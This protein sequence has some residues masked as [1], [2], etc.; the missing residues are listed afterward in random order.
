MTKKILKVPHRGQQLSGGDMRHGAEARHLVQDDR[1]EVPE[2]GDRAQEGEA[3]RQRPHLQ[4][5]ARLPLLG[6]GQALH[7]GS[8]ASLRVS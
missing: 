7:P 3:A 5:G 1:R 2:G 6:E 8:H 4:Q